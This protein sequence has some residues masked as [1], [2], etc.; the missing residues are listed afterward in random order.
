M[1]C[2]IVTGV[3]SD[4]GFSSFNLTRRGNKALLPA[5]HMT[6]G[7]ACF[8]VFFNLRAIMCYCSSL[9]PAERRKRRGEESHQIPPS[10]SVK[11]GI[12]SFN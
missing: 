11:Y 12:G 6:S 3:F 5:D 8:I 7:L 9:Q 10:L 1:T 4:C 2:S